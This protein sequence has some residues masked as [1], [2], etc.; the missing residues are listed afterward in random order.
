MNIIDKLFNATLG[1]R[2]RSDSDAVIISCFFNPQKSAYRTAAFKKFYETIKHLDYRITECVIGN[3]E[4]EFGHLP[5]VDV[6]RT[7]N[8]LWHKEALLNR[9]VKDLPRRFKYVFWI[10]AD[11]IFTNKH[12]LV[13]SCKVLRTKAKIIQPFEYCIH[14]EQDETAPN[15][16]ITESQ[17][18]QTNNHIN[19][20]KEIRRLWRSFASNKCNPKFHDTINKQINYDHHG[21]VGFAWGIHREILDHIDLYD[22][23][24]IGGADHIIA[25]AAVGEF[26][27]P[28]ITK[29]FGDTP[30][31][32]RWQQRFHRWVDGKI[33]FVK[34]DLY[35]IWHGDITKR[36]YLKRIQEFMPTAD[37]IQ[38][39][40]DNGLYVAG[41]PIPYMEDYFENREVS[42]NHIVEES[43]FGGFKDGDFGGAGV[44]GEWEQTVKGEDMLGV[45]H[46]DPTVLSG[47][48]YHDANME[49]VA[50]DPANENH[51]EIPN[52]NFS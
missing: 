13:D 36:E 38:K 12:W 39:K 35:H 11:V 26:P 50:P 18:A 32:L 25:H 44:S 1:Q 51:S 46:G 27:F 4:P 24:L 7:Q 23:A 33:G 28:C 22:R 30:D 48:D 34:G 6:V 2:Y 43:K 14:M 45:H 16:H 49:F 37:A 5:Y 40:D 52:D 47:K 42:P 3:D 21:H 9:I 10:D 41:A 15:Y 29:S 19:I 8:L 31:I 17:R 20:P